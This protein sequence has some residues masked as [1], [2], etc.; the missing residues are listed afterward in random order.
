LFFFF[1]FF[2]FFFFFFYGLKILKKKIEKKLK[3]KIENCLK[4]KHLIKKYKYQHK[5]KTTAKKQMMDQS[6]DQQTMGEDELVE[7]RDSDDEAGMDEDDETTIEDQ[8][9]FRAWKTCREMV[10][11]RG[12]DIDDTD[13]IEGTFAENFETLRARL[14]YVEGK[15]YVNAVVAAA[16]AAAAAAAQTSSCQVESTYN[17]YTIIKQ[18]HNAPD[19]EPSIYIYATRDKSP[20]S[21]KVIFCRYN[22]ATQKCLFQKQEQQQKDKD[23]ENSQYTKQIFIIKNNPTSILSNYTIFRYN[24]V[25]FNRTHHRLVP[26]HKLLSDADKAEVLRAYDCKESQIPRITKTD[27]IARYFGANVGDMFAIHRPSPSCGTYVTYR[28]VK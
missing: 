18:L 14:T 28:L 9:V 8:D 21:L 11:D 25:I 17:N 4:K 26:P 22:K 23:K 2:F 19:G 5:K 6:D 27:F 20:S 12:Y 15:A 13:L 10:T 1:V 24:E 16:A 7:Q 3:K